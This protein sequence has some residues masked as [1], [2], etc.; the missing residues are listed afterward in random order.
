M[1]WLVLRDLVNATIGFE[2][3][4]V[5]MG[6]PSKSLHRMLSAK[7][8]PTMESPRTGYPLNQK[9]KAS[10]GHPNPKQMES[11]TMVNQ[12][13]VNPWN[14]KRKAY[15]CDD[16]HQSWNPTMDY[17]PSTPRTG[18]CHQRINGGGTAAA[19][20]FSSNKKR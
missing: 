4:A 6:K 3:L 2:G 5:V 9:T 20:P 10:G 19:V 15:G 14:R 12:K 13:M 1:A 8:N 16:G 11:R 18:C 7:G 17:P